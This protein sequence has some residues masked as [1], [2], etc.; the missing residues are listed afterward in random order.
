M[1]TVHY[2]TNEI[3]FASKVNKSVKSIENV[4]I[5]V[6]LLILSYVYLSRLVN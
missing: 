3:C 1:F 2:K 5:V 4:V 6:V